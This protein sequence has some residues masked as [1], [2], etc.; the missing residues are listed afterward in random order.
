MQPEE[1][2]PAL[3]D[4]VPADSLAY[5]GFSNLSGTLSQVLQ[6]VQ[7]TLSDEERR[8]LEG[9]TGQ[10]PQLLGVTLDD[11]SALAEGEHA[12]VVTP[13]A[14]AGR[15]ARARGGGRRPAQATLDKL[16]T[17]IPA[18]LRT[19]S[20]DTQIPEW[21]RVPL[22]GGVAG[23]A[24]AALA[25]GRRGLRRG[26]RPRH[27]RHQR[28]RRDLGAA[29]R[30]PALR[31]GRLPGG[32]GRDARA[33]DLGAL[34]QPRQDSIAALDNAGAFDDA[35]PKTLANLRPLKSIAAWTTAGETPTFEVFARIQG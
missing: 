12:L 25:R 3:T 28:P 16:R 23:L 14:D 19:F 35:T 34:A 30:R 29:P 6:Q 26:R 32:H 31:L 21:T 17:G 7:G 20:P 4:T 22:A 8:Q 2:T 27:P 13:G 11:L 24:P 18:L 15:G 1:F 5:L 33:G 9:F 10:V